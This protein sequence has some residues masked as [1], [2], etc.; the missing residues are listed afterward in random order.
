MFVLKSPWTG[1]S[2][3]VLAHNSCSQIP[4]PKNP[5]SGGCQRLFEELLVFP[6]GVGVPCL[7]YR[8]LTA[9]RESGPHRCE[10]GLRR[11]RGHTGV[12]AVTH[13]TRRS[14]F[15]T[16]STCVRRTRARPSFGGPLPLPVRVRAAGPFP[17][18]PASATDAFLAVR[19]VQPPLRVAERRVGSDLRCRSGLGRGF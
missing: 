5:A 10:T 11:V 14:A 18:H 19:R 1:L 3:E 12:M 8:F 9:V 4:P 16:A 17:T 7:T 13:G 15:L 2:P 6:Q